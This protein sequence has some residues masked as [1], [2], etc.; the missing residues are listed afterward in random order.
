MLNMKNYENDAVFV[1][2]CK[3]QKTK[4]KKI[5]I[6][7]QRY[8]FRQHSL[9]EKSP[10]ATDKNIFGEITISSFALPIS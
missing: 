7:F 10:T 9:V 6:K 2:N 3:K 4:K 8:L 5:K 1:E